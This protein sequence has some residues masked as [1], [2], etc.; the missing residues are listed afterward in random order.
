MLHRLHGHIST[1]KFKEIPDIHIHPQPYI[2]K[3]LVAEIQQIIL[4]EW[5]KV[6]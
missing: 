4:E 2:H 6:P 3:H 5:E 1:V